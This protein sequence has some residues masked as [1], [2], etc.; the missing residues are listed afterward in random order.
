MKRLTKKE[1]VA[2]HEVK[3]VSGDDC[4]D[5]WSVP[6]KFMG[7]AIDRLAAYEDT[8][9]MPEEIKD[10]IEMFHSYR[11][12]CAG[13]EPEQVEELAQAKKDGRLV[14]LPCKLGDRVYTLSNEGVN[15]KWVAEFMICHV[16]DGCPSLWA[17]LACTYESKEFVQCTKEIGKTVFLTIEEAE[18]ALKMEAKQNETD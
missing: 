6:Q 8:G 12:I 15:P 14:V 9:M 16:I 5:V 17:K 3:Y 18:E 2:G 11:H 4:F 7:E 10:I 1:M 13:L